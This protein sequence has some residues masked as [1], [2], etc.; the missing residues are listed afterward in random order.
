[1]TKYVKNFNTADDAAIAAIELINPTSIAQ[2][3][4]FAGRI[5]QRGGKFFFTTAITLN[6]SNYSEPG[7][8]VSNVKNIGTYH[9]HAGGFVETDEIF[10][11]QDK[12]KA[13]LAKE[14]SYLGTP[15]QRILKFIPLSLRSLNEHEG[16]VEVLQGVYV[17]PEITIVGD[18]G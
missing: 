3:V 14:I 9:T 10:S 6:Q 12:I 2:N 7:P 11:P 15:H 18:L 5:F 13:T 1:M 4:E 16:Q 8:K 17:M